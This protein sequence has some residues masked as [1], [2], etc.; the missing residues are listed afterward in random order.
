[1]GGQ[2][3][4]YMSCWAAGAAIERY[5][6][7]SLGGKEDMWAV[8]AV[9][10]ETCG[11]WGRGVVGAVWAVWGVGGGEGRVRAGVLGAVGVW[12]VGGGR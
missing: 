12:G 11:R 1:M 4:G 7:L 3:G 5:S 10:M 8:T 2:G 6:S 9:G